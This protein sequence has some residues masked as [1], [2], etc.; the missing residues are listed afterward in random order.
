MDTRAIGTDVSFWNSAVNFETM[1]AAGSKFCYA[2]ASQQSVDPRFKE[3]WAAMKTAKI[4]RGAYHYL[5][6]RISVDYQIRMFVAALGGDLGELPPVLDLEMNP[7]PLMTEL[8]LSPEQSFG[9]NRQY[10]MNPMLSPDGMLSLESADG[11]N[12]S[13]NKREVQGRVWQFLDGVEKLTG[14]IPMIYSGYY[15][16]NQWMTPDPA[17][18]R[19]PF[20]L[21]WYNTEDYIHYKTGGTGAPLPWTN[22]TMWQYDGNGNGPMYGSQGLSMDMNKFNGDTVALYTFAKLT[23]PAPVPIPTPVPTPTPGPAYKKYITTHLMNVRKSPE[24]T[25]SNLIGTIDPNTIFNVDNDSNP[26]WVHAVATD[27]PA[28]LKNGAY[29]SKLYVK[30][31]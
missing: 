9:M 26:N 21:A 12:Y 13:L 30:L 11:M 2:K 16:W 19:Y 25:D 5:D 18:K 23:P 20:W 6:W 10:K 29:L 3:Y 8:T 4:L 22:W 24:V 28:V 15:Y 31:V 7:A 17:W 1:V 27:K 14:R